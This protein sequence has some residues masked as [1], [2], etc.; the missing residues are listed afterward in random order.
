MPPTLDWICKSAVV[1]H[2]KEVPFRLL[3]CREDLS[4]GK[5]DSDNLLI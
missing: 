1:E 5:A 3:K 2:H 4:V